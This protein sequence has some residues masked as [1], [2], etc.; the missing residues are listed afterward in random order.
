[1]DRST[2][3]QL[4]KAATLSIL[5][6]TT[7]SAV[8]GLTVMAAARPAMSQPDGADGGLAQGSNLDPPAPPSTPTPVPPLP[9]P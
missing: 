5:V 2:V 8:A 4:I 7:T 9:V 1:M 6:L 3:G